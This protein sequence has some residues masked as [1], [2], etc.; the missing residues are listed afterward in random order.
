M[1]R[2]YLILNKKL[3]KLLTKGNGTITR[4]MNNKDM[5]T[6][7]RIINLTDIKLTNEQ[8]QLLNLGPNYAIEMEPKKYLNDLIIDT[9]NAIRHLDP[10]MQNTYRYLATKRINQISK[11]NKHNTLHKRQQYIIN[12]MKKKTFQRNHI[13]IAR[14]DKSKATVLIN[15]NILQR[16]VYEFL[17]ENGIKQINKDPH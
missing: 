8:T 1:K 12:E 17:Q 13:T 14:A 11:Q 4:N 15:K 7:Q 3:D 6:Q 5:H 10:K 2:K 9:E 16:K